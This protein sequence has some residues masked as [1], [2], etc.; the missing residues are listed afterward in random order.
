M[1]G[2]G[3]VDGGRATHWDGVYSG[4]GLTEMSWFQATPTASLELLDALGVS[5]QSAVIDVGGGASLLVDHLL[6]RGFDDVSVL[7]V[8]EAAL[9]SARSR[10]TSSAPVTWVRDDVLTW[11]PQRGFDLWHDRAVF[12]FLTDAVD[13]LTYLRTMRRALRP[14]GTVIVGT[15]ASDGPDHCS[16]L[17]VARYS[18]EELAD[19]IGPEF[20]IVAVRR[21][22]HTTP[23]GAVQP[24]SWLAG[25][26]R[27][28][29]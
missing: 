6:E 27:C 8:S 7:D 3:D 13:R 9:R 21:E 18:S 28:G 1:G 14:C 4:R 20:D 25:R 5:P 10:L 15:F 16:G 26:L 17:P 23:T 11:R 29:R 2:A 19:A 22:V 12:H 24:F